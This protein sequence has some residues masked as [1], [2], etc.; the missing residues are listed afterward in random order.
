MFLIPSQALGIIRWAN[1]LLVPKTSQNIGGTRRET[2]VVPLGLLFISTRRPSSE[3]R[4][5]KGGLTAS[6]NWKLHSK[7]ASD[8]QLH[9]GTPA[10]SASQPHMFK[11]RRE[12]RERAGL[13]QPQPDAPSSWLCLGPKPIPGL[14]TVAHGTGLPWLVTQ[15]TRTRKM[16]GMAFPEENGKPF[17]ELGWIDAQQPRNNIH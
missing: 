5:Q 16:R 3:R 2:D 15:C 6:H 11:S 8:L 10:A 7:C 17:P 9:V 4:K 1:R 12:A 13:Q 14:I